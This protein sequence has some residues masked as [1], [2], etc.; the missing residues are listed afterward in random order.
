MKAFLGSVAGPSVTPNKLCMSCTAQIAFQDHSTAKAK[1]SPHPAAMIQ[2]IF[3][4][5]HIYTCKYLHCCNWLWV[6]NRYPKWNPGKL[7]QRLKPAVP[8]WVNFDPYPNHLGNLHVTCVLAATL[9]LFHAPSQA[10]HS[11][12]PARASWKVNPAISLPTFAFGVYLQ[13]FNL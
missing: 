4:V 9:Q 11:S 6:K 13:K 10:Q 5:T 1:D 8:S 12:P 7:K 2:L 3:K